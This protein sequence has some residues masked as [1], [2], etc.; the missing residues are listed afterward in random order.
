MTYNNA[1][2]SRVKMLEK[3][4]EDDLKEALKK[5]EVVKVSTLRMLRAAIKNAAIENRRE[6]L[7]DSDI[8]GI[9]R[10]QIKQHKES[11]EAY[12]LGN[13]EDL[14]EKEKRE[15]D[16]LI[17]YM[18]PEFSEEEI[19]KVIIN[20]IEETGAKGKK[21]LGRVMKSV[22]LEL[23]G[24][25]DGKLVNKIVME[26]LIEQEGGDDNGSTEK[27]QAVS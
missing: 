10:K 8:V 12:T 6:A 14:V 15:L 11:I 26:K 1:C 18:P 13:R 9:L 17:S 25:A 7:E 5:K 19:V 23:K 4:I 3:R 24:R 21:D 20:K 22:M 27:S 2:Q 16:I